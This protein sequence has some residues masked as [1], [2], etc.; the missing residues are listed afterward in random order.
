MIDLNIPDDKLKTFLDAYF[1]WSEKSEEEQ[2]YIREQEEL[3]RRL[4]ETL[5]SKDFLTNSA[6]DRLTQEIFDYSRKL[7]GPVHIR[8]GQERISDRAEE[9]KR[10][11]LYLIESP[12]S[13]IQKAEKVLDGEYRIPI[14]AK[15]FWSP[16]F[17]AQFPETLPNWNNKTE[18]FF[19]KL[20]IN[21]RSSR[22]PTTGERYR[23]ISD[24]FKRFKGLNPRHDFYT[25]NH[26]MHFGTEIEE[27]K[28][29]IVYI[30]TNFEEL[31]QGNELQ[32]HVGTYVADRHSGDPE[33]WSEEYK[34]EILPQVH[35]EFVA[36][37]ITQ[38]N[39]VEKISILQAR[40]PQSGSFVHWSNLDDLKTLAEHHSEEV[41]KELKGLFEGRGHLS[42]RINK[43]RENL[44]K[45]KGDANLGTPLFGYLFAAYDPERFSLYKD[46][47]FLFIRSFFGKDDSWQSLSIGMKYQMFQG[48]CLAMGQFLNDQN[49]LRK[50]DT[51]N[52]TVS[53][54]IVPLDGQDFFFHLGWKAEK[55][56]EGDKQ[57]TS[58]WRVVL[59]LDTHDYVIWPE[60]K[61]RGLVAIG[62]QRDPDDYS[63]TRMR[64]RMK[65]GD[66]V[67]GYLLNGRVGGVGTITGEY[68]DYSSDKPVEKDYFN[69]RFWRWRQVRWDH[70]PGE[71]DFWQLPPPYAETMPGGRSTI[72]E[73]TE[74]QFN[75][76]L[77]LIGLREKTPNEEASLS[78]ESVLRKIFL[79]A[80]KFDQ[81]IDLLENSKKNQIILQGPPGT[82]KT[83]IAQRI[84]EYLA[85]SEERVETIQFHPS[86]SYEDFIEG[87][88]PTEGGDFELQEGVFRR[89]CSRAADDPERK[90]VLVI[91]EINRSNL[92]KV[93]GE[94]MYLLEY[95]DQEVKL[96]YS[97]QLFSIPINLY[98]IGTMNTA[99][100]SLAIMDYALRRRFCFVDLQCQTERL[101]GWLREND[102]GLDVGRLVEQI[103]TMNKRIA[104]EMRSKDFA[105][106]HSY[107]MKEGLD[108]SWLAQTLE[109]EIKPLLEEYFFDKQ[110][111]VE[112]ILGIL[113]QD[114]G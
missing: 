42:L 99:D 114:E 2:N 47:T 91:D 103:K 34:W 112:E 94:L 60:C 57:G 26:F 100:R 61:K 90:Y 10:N 22:Y 8:L 78:R 86:Y 97:Q 68:E 81:I 104:E 4:K 37:E 7:E 35:Q 79:G 14:F 30:N 54:G 20:G 92:S 40:N 77:E 49:R 29:L 21:L 83:F 19:R 6:H 59:P 80:E 24:T 73:L 51:R 107:F 93:F 72:S 95:R 113:E 56:R 23:I 98:I 111:K 87:Y 75:K 74:E 27:G 110:E 1:D 28:D 66:K 36:E 88:R 96:A 55:G 84:A 38:S 102:C 11:L 85:G 31:V 44:K 13:P 106:G 53:P 58:Y 101:G 62:F 105:I 71:E 33:R 70:L 76:V 82:G 32:E 65:V 39:V 17:L 15:A 25:L 48:L 67:I 52:V 109:F 43:F 12:D 9:V 63:V 46:S 50:V 3:S 16:I 41:A 108:K 5:L 64:D 69:G 89:F 18:R 45:L